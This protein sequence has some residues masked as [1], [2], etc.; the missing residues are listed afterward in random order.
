VA[1]ETSG[2]TRL[3]PLFSA[4]LDDRQRV[5]WDALAG[6]G[7]GAKAIRPEGFLTGPFDVLL[8]SP[9]I[10][11]AVAQLGDLLRF[12]S[13]LS[14]R[15]RELVICTVAG[16]WQASYAWLRHEEYA[17]AAGLEAEAVAA[18]AADRRPDFGCGPEGPLDDLVWRCAHALT[19][20]G[21]L[22][23]ELY[24]EAVT[25]LGETAVV[26]LT[27]LSGYYCV[28]SF[29]LNTFDVPLPVGASV[30]W[31]RGEAE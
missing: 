9:E 19:R 13:E 1:P 25:T 26:E 15:H 31:G 23:R 27:T 17:L 14:D 4:D 10:G 21:R 2:S 30:P 20:T 8:R 16:R 24:D 5:L 29:L 11:A 12:Q 3:P 7:R 28:C 22:D 18:I 6:G